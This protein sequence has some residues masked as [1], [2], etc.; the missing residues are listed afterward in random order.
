M[1]SIWQIDVS[2]LSSYLADLILLYGPRLVLAFGVIVLGYMIGRGLAWTVH[3]AV[4][5]G[6]FGA[7][8]K[9]TSIG[10]AILLSGYTPAQ[11]FASLAKWS[12]YL[13]AVYEAI[14]VLGIPALR[15]FLR[16]I[17]LY[18]PYF[19]SGLLILIV[20]FIFADSVADIVKQAGGGSKANYYNPFGDAVR[21]FLYFVVLVM[22]LAQMKIDVTI[23]YI[24]AQAFAWS[25]AIAV[26]IA[27]GW[28][29]KDRIGPWIEQILPKASRVRR[30]EKEQ[31]DA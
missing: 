6:G 13:I 27:L 15:T 31:P 10:R 26:A 3:G 18:L 7:V 12:V 5:R 2:G 16:E 11:F 1:P 22:A 30:T 24:F 19:F 21:I 29:L 28:N 4:Q 14:E 20:G 23:L 9:K 25:I 8:F 17:V